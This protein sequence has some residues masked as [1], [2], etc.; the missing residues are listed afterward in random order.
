MCDQVV[1]GM[2]RLNMQVV[3]DAQLV[4]CEKYLEKADQNNTDPANCNWVKKL[5][6]VTKTAYVLPN[7]ASWCTGPL[8]YPSEIAS[9]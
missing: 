8:R 9:S 2:T 6:F 4:G 3:D 1:G 7:S 5:L